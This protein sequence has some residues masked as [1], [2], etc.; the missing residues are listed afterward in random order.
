MKALTIKQPWA[1][2]IA[3][4]IKDVEN[5]TWR[6]HFRGRIYIHASA[7]KPEYFKN[8]TLVQLHSLPVEAKENVVKRSYCTSAIIGE[9]EIVD[10]IKDSKSIWAIEGS[11]HWVLKNAVMYE[12]P[13]PNVKGKL[14]FWEFKNP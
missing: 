11:W 2:L 10:C 13:I 6:T 5:R 12:K 1:H 8:L 9:V 3:L 7:S 4:G 14:S